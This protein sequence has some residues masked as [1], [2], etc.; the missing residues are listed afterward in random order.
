MS[1]V[2]DIPFALIDLPE[3]S[4]GFDERYEDVADLAASIRKEGLWY[5]LIVHPEGDRYRLRDGKRRWHA[6]KQLN[7]QK[8]RCIVHGAA[9][10][11]AE[12]VKLKA[13]LLGKRNN[14]AEIAAHLG[15]LASKFGWSLERITTEVGMSESW[16]NDHTDLLRGDPDVLQALGEEKINFAQARE[17]NRCKSPGLR[18]EG[19]RFAMFDNIPSGKLRDWIKR[20]DNE[21][22]GNA[23]A[24][25]G[26][27]PVAVAQN[28]NSGGVQ[29]FCCGGDKDPQNMEN[30]WIHR[31]EL[32]II[33]GVLNQGAA[34][35]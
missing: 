2:K 26:A 13:N 12:A 20:N 24:P 9:D 27:A 17:L 7:I 18:A 29:C 31:W 14:H 35:G 1:K 16:V 4:L 15:E 5:P 21:Q 33:R 8:V 19:L 22:P 6:L 23:G 32:D 25:E 10:P 11:P 28:G 30:I 34:K 3:I